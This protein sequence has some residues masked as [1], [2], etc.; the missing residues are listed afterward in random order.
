MP[1]GFLGLY[2]YRSIAESNNN[3][4]TKEGNEEEANYWHHI[5]GIL[6]KTLGYSTTIVNLFSCL[7]LF[8]TIRHAYKLTKQVAEFH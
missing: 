1:P 7:I 6:L 3:Y 4:Y 2:I 8:L 5:D